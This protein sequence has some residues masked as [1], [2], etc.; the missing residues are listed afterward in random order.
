MSNFPKPKYG[1][2]LVPG[3]Y[4]YQVYRVS[5]SEEFASWNF[6]NEN[7]RAKALANAN[8]TRNDLNKHS[9]AR[10]KWHTPK[11]YDEFATQLKKRAVYVKD[12][13]YD[14][15]VPVRQS[16]RTSSTNNNEKFKIEVRFRILDPFKMSLVGDWGYAT[17]T[18]T[19]LKFYR[20]ANSFEDAQD[21]N[22]QFH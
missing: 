5:D 22:S 19:D 13:D 12:D 21:P 16:G 6:T 18:D 3:E 9:T 14:C 17:V 8:A 7:S 10:A 2:R 1:V 4:R 15:W 11:N 20:I